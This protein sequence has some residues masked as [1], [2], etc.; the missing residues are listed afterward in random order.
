MKSGRIVAMTT[1]GV[2]VRQDSG[3]LT[4]F[5]WRKDPPRSTTLRGYAAIVSSSGQHAAVTRSDAARPKPAPSLL[6][7]FGISFRRG[8]SL[9]DVID[10]GTN[11]TARSSILKD[12]NPVAFDPV[13]DLFAI[14]EGGGLAIYG[15]RGVEPLWTIA[16]VVQPLVQFSPNGRFL[17][18]QRHGHAEMYRARSGEL[19]WKLDSDDDPGRCRWSLDSTLLACHK[20]NAIAIVRAE[21]G[22]V[23]WR[24]SD[25]GL[26]ESPTALA[27]SEDGRML[28]AAIGVQIARIPIWDADAILFGCEVAGRNLT[29]AEWNF[30][31]NDA[32]PYRK[33][34][35]AF[36]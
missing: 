31:L 20:E 7:A 1:E 25:V 22:G 2:L 6:A 13:G 19:V 9:V 15:A 26:T 24:M 32:V 34:C 5:D 29:I 30:F 16:K 21:S 36:P 35:P 11:T 17:L 3:E 27:T 14:E 23:M 33:T 4:K 10:L 18:V 12:K 28:H 8:P